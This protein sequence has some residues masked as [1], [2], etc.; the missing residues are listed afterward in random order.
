MYGYV[1]CWV[2][3][4]FRLDDLGFREG[5][6]FVYDLFLNLLKIRYLLFCELIDIGRG[7]CRIKLIMKR[8]EELVIGFLR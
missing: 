8:V 1:G 5:K 4:V 7:G 2:K 6:I 3:L